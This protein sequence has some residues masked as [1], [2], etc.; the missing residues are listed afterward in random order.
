M[1]MSVYHL[2]RK[3]PRKLPQIVYGDNVVYPC[4]GHPSVVPQ[5]SI[6]LPLAFPTSLALLWTRSDLLNGSGKRRYLSPF[7]GQGRR[8]CLRSLLLDDPYPLLAGA[9][10]GLILLSLHVGIHLLIKLSR[11]LCDRQGRLLKKKKKKKKK[12][13][14]NLLFSSICIAYKTKEE[15]FEPKK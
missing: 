1:Y 14:E 5:A 8:S 7:K 11:H 6:H 10:K 2:V 15:G 3:D 9:R 12:A 4:Q 13:H